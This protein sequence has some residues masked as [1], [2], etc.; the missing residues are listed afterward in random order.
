MMCQI[1]TDSCLKFPH[2]TESP[3][4]DAAIR[5]KSEEAFHLVEPTRAGG[6]EMQVIARPPHKPALDL[7][8][9]VGAIVIQ[10]K[11]DVEGFGNG[12]IDAFQKSQKLLMSLP[13]MQR[14]DDFAGGDIQCSKQGCCAMANVVVS[15]SCRHARP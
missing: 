14:T 2:A 1:V 12:G 8:H 9:F 7:W 13:A 10:H 4:T 5:E 6:C 3:A 15:Q 11:M